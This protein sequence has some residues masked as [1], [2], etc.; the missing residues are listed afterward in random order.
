ML[1]QRF[2]MHAL[3]IEIVKFHR[4]VGGNM[5]GADV[6][7]DLITPTA[8]RKRKLQFSTAYLTDAPTVVVRRGTTIRDLAT[9]QDLRWGAIRA[10]TFVEDIQTLV[11]PDQPVRT[12]DDQPEMLAALESKQIDAV[13]FDLPLA[14][15]IS[16]RSNGRLKVAAQLPTP[17]PIAAALPKG[18]GNRQAVDSAI[19]AF[20]ADGTVDRLL[21]KWVG[22]AAASAD[23]SIPLLH[24]TR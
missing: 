5:A 7:L 13:M 11:D 2:E 12:F 16:D 19:R 15:A 24:T 23:K 6:A 21:R 17:E 3:R 14:V 18:S 22:P 9:A 8:E 20:I 10:T 1:A 4:L